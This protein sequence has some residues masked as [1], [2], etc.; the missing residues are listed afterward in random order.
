MLRWVLLQNSRRVGPTFFEMETGGF[1][2]DADKARIGGARSFFARTPPSVG[3]ISVRLGGLDKVSISSEGCHEKSTPPPCGGESG[4]RPGKVGS[5]DSSLRQRRLAWDGGVNAPGPP[6][7][8]PQAKPPKGGGGNLR[9]APP[10]IFHVSRSTPSP[11]YSLS[12]HI[13]LP[14]C[15]VL[16]R[17]ALSLSL[18]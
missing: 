2:I 17:G 1:V 11:F 4:P 3:R 7:V 9:W 6:L 18:S 15:S 5:R 14:F 16:P 12:P 8:R 10:F 13:P